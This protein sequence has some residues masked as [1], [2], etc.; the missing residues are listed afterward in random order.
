VSLCKANDLLLFFIYLKFQGYISQKKG[1]KNVYMIKRDYDV[2]GEGGGDRV[3]IY[4]SS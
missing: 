1:K 3:S 2:K 4:N